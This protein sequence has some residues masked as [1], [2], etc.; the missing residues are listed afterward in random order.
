MPGVI[1]DFNGT[2]FW[3]SSYHERAWRNFAQKQAGKTLT[4]DDMKNHVH[5]RIN[6]D[7]LGYVF[8]KTLCDEEVLHYSNIKEQMYRDLIVSSH[9]K[10]L[11]PG[12]MPL[13]HELKAMTIPFTIA[14]SS[15]VSNVE[16][17]CDYLNLG[18]WFDTSK[19]VYDDGSINP[20][21]APDIFLKA[22]HLLGVSIRD[23]V[24]LED[25]VTGIQ[26]ARNADA[27]KVLLVENDVPSCFDRVK[28]SVDGKITNLLHT[29]NWL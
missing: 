29:L 21:P 26:S 16:F 2:L 22:A 1:F 27:G 5:G 20:K 11:A 17:Y 12:S 3:D 24:V 28:N 4:E 10:E 14:T 15:E 8:S 13:F 19:I 23:C 7:I 9:L 6:R 18:H 25:S